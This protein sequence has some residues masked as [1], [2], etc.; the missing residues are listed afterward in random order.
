MHKRMRPIFGLFD[1]PVFHRIDPTI[2]NMHIEIALS[3]ARNNFSTNASRLS[4][5][6]SSNRQPVRIEMM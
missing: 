2:Q 5:T 1:E 3:A 6:P 4:I